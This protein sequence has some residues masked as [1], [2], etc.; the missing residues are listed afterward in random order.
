MNNKKLKASSDSAEYGH[1]KIINYNSDYDFDFDEAEQQKSVK[2]NKVVYAGKS[3]TEEEEVVTEVDE[4]EDDVL[5]RKIPLGKLSLKTDDQIVSQFLNLSSN[6]HKTRL[7]AFKKLNKFKEKGVMRKELKR[8]IFKV[9]ENEILKDSGS[10]DIRIVRV[11]LLLLI[12]F[13]LF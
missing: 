6:D 1:R 4:D 10:F 12:H 3:D 8:N 5:K 2:I 11:F 13:N 9:I 7:E